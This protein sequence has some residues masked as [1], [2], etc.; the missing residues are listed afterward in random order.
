MKVKRVV[1]F[2]IPGDQGA[3]VQDGDLRAAGGER[4]QAGH[5]FRHGLPHER[6]R[7]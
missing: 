3:G 4:E 6:P 5:R 1:K 7:R 2:N